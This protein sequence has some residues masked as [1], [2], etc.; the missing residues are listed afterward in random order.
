MLYEVITHVLG[1]IGRIDARDVE[2]LEALG[3]EA[4]Y[5]GTEYI[6]KRGVEA[7]YQQWLHGETGFEQVEIDAGG[8][9]IRSLSQTP[10]RPGRNVTLV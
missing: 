6:G 9:G 1:Y 4:N 3:V 10:A 5:R 7:T 8:R 2:E